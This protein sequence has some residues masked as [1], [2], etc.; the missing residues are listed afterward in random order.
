MSASGLNRIG[1]ILAGLLFVVLGIFL[2]APL[3]LDGEWIWGSYIDFLIGIPIF[4]LGSLLVVSG[5][6]LKSRSSQVPKGPLVD[7][8]I[9]EE[10][11]EE[12]E[13]E[14]CKK[15]LKTDEELLALIAA[16]KEKGPN[17]LAVTNK[18][19]LIYPQGNIEGVVSYEYEQ[20]DEVKG[21]RNTFFVH[22]GEIS[23][24]VKGSKVIFKTVGIEYIDKIV[25][26]VSNMKRASKQI[27]T[28]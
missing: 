28:P 6:R 11:K 5:L 22:L 14:E 20:I 7:E 24:S 19:V 26:L 1:L 25:E 27:Q 18:S 17:R 9:S 8:W 13:I 3:P 23:L 12:A 21:K 2:F 15:M 10:G 4:I 16:R